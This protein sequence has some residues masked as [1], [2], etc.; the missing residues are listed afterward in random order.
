MIVLCRKSRRGTQF[1]PVRGKNGGMGRARSMRQFVGGEEKKTISSVEGER[2]GKTS[3]RKG[4]VLPLY[5][6]FVGRGKREAPPRHASRKRKGE[7]RTLNHSYSELKEKRKIGDPLP[8]AFR[9]RGEKRLHSSRR[10]KKKSSSFSA[11]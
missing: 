7:K 5:L 2:K 10:C 9:M 3:S 8:T 1:A 4:G 11:G 6:H